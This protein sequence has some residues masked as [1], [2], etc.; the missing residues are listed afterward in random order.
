MLTWLGLLLFPGAVRSLPIP[1]P[2]LHSTQRDAAIFFILFGC[3]RAS[4][5]AVHSRAEDDLVASSTRQQPQQVLHLQRA[6]GGPQG[7]GDEDDSEEAVHDGT[8]DGGRGGSIL[9]IGQRIGGCR[10]EKKIGRRNTP[11]FIYMI[12]NNIALD[13][14]FLNDK[15]GS[16]LHNRLFQNVCLK[17]SR[18]AIP[19]NKF[20]DS[21]IWGSKIAQGSVALCTY[22]FFN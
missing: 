4:A 11:Y 22:I 15:F 3:P 1:P 21:L 20:V 16:I 10:W 6:P 18:S 12:T 9:C 2:L 17:I 14:G 5:Q 19:N 13:G 8:A 7:G